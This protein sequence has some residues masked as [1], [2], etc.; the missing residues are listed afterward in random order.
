MPAGLTRFSSSARDVLSL[1]HREAVQLNHT[2]VSPGHILIGLIQDKG[3]AGQ[4]LAGQRANLAAVRKIVIDQTPDTEKAGPNPE[5]IDLSETTQKL[6]EQAVR[7]VR[8][9]QHGMIGNL[10]LLLALVDLDDQ[11]TQ[12]ILGQAGLDREAIREL[13][14]K[15]LSAQPP[16]IEFNDLLYTLEKLR[17]LLAPDLTPEDANRLDRI[18]SILR[19]H[20]HF[21]E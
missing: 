11:R 8:Q 19:D 10:H 3:E 16:S 7:L 17:H 20:F 2:R 15:S 18:E 12:T 4:I 13:A 5:R 6:L 9:Y 1:A 21:Q 14:Q